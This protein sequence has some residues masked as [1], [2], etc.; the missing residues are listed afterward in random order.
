MGHDRRTRTLIVV[1]FFITYFVWGS[2]YLANDWA[3]HEIP[4]YL[5]ASV[6]FSIAGVILL[7]IA[8]IYA[9]LNATKRQI[10]N[11]AVVGLLMFA[12]GNGLA[13]WSLNYIDSGV[14]AILIALQPLVIVLIEWVFR[15]KRPNRTTIC[16]ICLGVVGVVLL[17]GQP[18]FQ[19]GTGPL[20]ALLAILVAITSWGTA[21]VWIPTAD[22]PSSMFERVA[23]QM[24]FGSVFL[25]PAS[26]CLGEFETFRFE[27]VTAYGF[28]SL[29]YLIV[30]GSLAALT[31]FNYLLTKVP[32]AKVV[33]NT[34]VN[35]IIAV[36]LG[37]LF[38][39][40]KVGWRTS[41]AAGFLLTGVFLIVQNRKRKPS[42]DH[43]EIEAPTAK[44]PTTPSPQDNNPCAVKRHA[45]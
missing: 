27:D 17:T 39:G 24:L 14:S 19:T 31:A 18:Q 23:L 29:V 8:R 26:Y 35:P 2:T 4:A 34:Y 7:A 41:V 37:W 10:R 12:M 28:W 44:L 5:L 43:E 6:R 13:V 32:P 25:F 16:G 11:S 20:L 3:V 22:L 1:S 36:F 9:P 42:T 15:S 40:E 38:N 21:T 45:P 33:T 30:F